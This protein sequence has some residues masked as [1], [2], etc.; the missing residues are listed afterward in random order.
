MFRGQ[1]GHLEH[2]HRME[3]EAEREKKRAAKQRRS[4]RVKRT[5][6]FLWKVSVTAFLLTLVAALVAALVSSLHESQEIAKVRARETHLAHLRQM[7]ENI[8]AGVEADTWIWCVDRCARLGTRNGELY[9]EGVVEGRLFNHESQLEMISVSGPWLTHSGRRHITIEI[10]D[11]L[12]DLNS[13]RFDIGD[14]VRLHLVHE[15]NGWTIMPRKLHLH[16]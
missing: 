13:P 9:S 12:R 2:K 1:D 16:D 8:P 4:E 3:E 6:N 15:R 11:S 5:A 14:V 10:T 7:K